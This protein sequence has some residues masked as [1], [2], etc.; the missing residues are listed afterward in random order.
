LDVTQIAPL[1]DV[2]FKDANAFG[3]KA[4]NVAELDRCLPPGMA[5]QGFAVP[6]YFYDVFMQH[7]DFYTM[8]R[9]MMEDPNFQTAPAHRVEALGAFRKQIRK[10]SLLPAWMMQSLQS[11]HEQFDPNT[12]LRCRSSTN[13]EDLPEFNG[14][15]LY[16]SYTHHPHEGHMAKSMKQVWASLWTYR[17]FEERDFYRIDH[18]STA[19]GVLVHPNYSDEQVNGVAIT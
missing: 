11:L 15:G 6:S 10:K 12:S 17:A 1:S 8:A 5:P 9:H 16:D 14:A 18:F 3:A 19:M 7:N 2:Q 13:N 4:V